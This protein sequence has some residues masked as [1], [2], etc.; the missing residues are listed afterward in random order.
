MDVLLKFIF[1]INK[2]NHYVRDS[3]C[4][5]YDPIYID[6]TIIKGL[7]DNLPNVADLLSIISE[8]A[9]GK[10]SSLIASL[11]EKEISEESEKKGK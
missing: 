6:E 3:W 9:T 7:E 2:V 10:K 11:E 8:K 5:I 1:D 4:E